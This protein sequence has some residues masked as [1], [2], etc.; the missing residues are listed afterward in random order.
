MRLAS[1]TLVRYGNYDAER[2][3]F[4]HKPGSVNILLAP[5]S[6]GKSVLRNAFGD[7]LFGIHN[8]TP[9]GFR[10]GYPGM[11]V[12]ADIVRSDGSSASFSRRKVRGNIISDDDGQPIDLGLLHG[13][14]GGR[15]RRL[16]ERL[17]V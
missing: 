9:M 17:F 3:Y 14:L 16:L 4:D 2:I 7:L 13:I 10:F 5:N 6:A 15:D 8:Q 11:R 1:I 12:A